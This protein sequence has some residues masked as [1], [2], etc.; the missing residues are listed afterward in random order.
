MNQLLEE[1]DELRR[2]GR[3]DEA[4]SL[5]ERVLAEQSELAMAWWGLAHTVMNQ[6]EFELA[7]EHFERAI[8]LEPD[9]QRI[10]YD[11]GMMYTMLGE[12]EAAAPLFNR[13]VEIAPDSKEGT[14]AQQQLSYY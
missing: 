11:F 10:L 1:A 13:V 5:Y 14:Q 7:V 9:N 4:R 8:E 6:G 3:Y 12:Y 2:N